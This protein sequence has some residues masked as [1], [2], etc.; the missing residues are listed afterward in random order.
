MSEI[1]RAAASSPCPAPTHGPWKGPLPPRRRRPDRPG[2][3]HRPAA[4][5]AARESVAAAVA[6]RASAPARWWCGST[7]PR[8]RT[9]RPTSPRSPPPRP[10]RAGAQGEDLRCADRGGLA[11]APARGAGLD[12]RLGD[13]RDADG[14]GQRR[15]DR[16]RRPRRGC[17]ALALVVGPN[18]LLKAGRIPPPG[19]AALVPWLMQV[20]PPPAPTRSRRSTAST[21]TSGRGRL[22]SRV[23]PGRELGFDGK[24]LIHPSQI[25]RPTPPSPPIRRNWPWPAASPPCSTRRR[26]TGSASSPS[27]GGWSSGCMS[28][29]RGGSSPWPRP[30]TRLG[31]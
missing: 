24:M 5:A 23:P 1:V 4:K 10:M 30:S 12:P 29:R 16:Q 3:R 8:R 17:A 28:R 15:R 22:R 19:R 6:A 2:G 26:T 18:D 9:A 31:A 25:G 13:D 11:P 21:R 7:R 20:S 27:R 14:G